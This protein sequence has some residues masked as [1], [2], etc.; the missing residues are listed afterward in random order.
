ML[1]NVYDKYPIIFSPYPWGDWLLGSKFLASKADFIEMQ[2]YFISSA[3][4]VAKNRQYFR[5][6]LIQ[7]IYQQ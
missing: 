6:I 4:Y 3:L 2:G 7:K 1:Q 5:R